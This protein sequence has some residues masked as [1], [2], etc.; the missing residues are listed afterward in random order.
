MKYLSKN[1]QNSKL[2]MNLSSI[3]F[4]CK[5]FLIFFFVI[6]FKI[7]LCV[8]KIIKNPKTSVR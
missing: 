3:N 1:N 7:I 6:L 2:S 4:L 5:S 8:T